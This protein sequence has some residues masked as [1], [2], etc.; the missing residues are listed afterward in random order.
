MAMI[1]LSKEATV[2]KALTP[3]AILMMLSFPVASQAAGLVIKNGTVYNANG[4]PVVDI[5]KSNGSGL[6]HNIWD[7]LNVDKNGVVFNN[8]ANE[9]STSLAGNI[10]GN[11][12]LTSGSAKVILNEVTSKNPSTING[13]MEVAG[14]KAD[15]IIANPNGITVNGGGSINTGKLTL[16]TG[17]PD[18]QDDKL[19]GYSVNGGTITLGKLDN[20][21][22][23][24]ILSRN[25]VVN[26]KVS[27]DELNVV[28]GNNY[29]NA[30]GQV[31]GSVSATGSRNGYSVDVAKLGGM[32]ANKINLVSTEKGVGVRNL[33][34]IAGGANG[35]SID[36]K[37]NLL[38]SN[39]QIQSASTINL[40]TN[41]TLDNTTG[42]VTSVG[43]ISL[44]TNKNTIVNTRAGNISTM[45]DIYVNSGTIDNT[46]GKLAA[47]GMLAVDTNSATL[48]NSG[49]GSSV[50]IEA[51]IVA[52]K[53]GTLNNSNGQIRGGYVGLESAALNNNNGDIQT[54][55]DIAIISNGN[56]DNNKGLIRSSTGHIV[57]GAAGSVN[58]G[59]TKT[60]DTG[61][62]DS[63]GIIADTGVEI[64]ANN[65]NNNGGQIASNGNVSL[66]SYST[67]DDYAGKVLSNS[68]VIIKGSSLRNDTG[69]ISAK[70]GIEV[71]V[72]GS[73]TNNIGVISSEE[74]DIS[75]LANSVDNHGGFMMGQNITMESM[76][77]VNN[78]TALIVASKKLKINAFGNIENRDGNSFGNTYGVYFGM[79]QQTGGMVG[80]EGIELSGQNI[81]N[82]N[83]RFIA[84]D[85]PLTLQ[86]QN[87]F[88]NTRALITSG[89]DAIIRAAG[90]FYNNY[91]TTYSA[92]NL[93]VY[94][95]SL[96]NASDGRLEDNT[97]TG[98]IAS[99]KNLDL[100]VDSS[101]TNYGWIS[102]K[103][104]VHF[105]VLK[106]TLY[107]RNA[108]AADN[109]LT[110]N[111]QNGV[112]NFKDIVAGTALTIDTQKYV[113]NNSNSNML[114]QTIAINAVNDINNRGNIVGDYSLGVKT[115]GNIYNYLNMLS[116]GV[117]GVSANKVTNSGKD[118]VLG[119][120]YGLALEANE[121]DNTGTIVGM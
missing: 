42:T 7:N 13:M 31:T 91:A 17:T 28:A 86:A 44:N 73:L 87:T 48:I 121:T 11:S 60:A 120:F 69:G 62:S 58:N 41:G 108:I 70:Q 27:A 14:D 84:E 114:G 95:A 34:V 23:T 107:N 24:E 46:N 72:G 19:A 68:K 75:L 33:G 8:S 47:A 12:N 37:G 80:N 1:N 83:S 30:A 82:N 6:S 49:K 67:I 112:E 32:Y 56:V 50:G 119:G 102:G 115:T 93:D 35:V 96:N 94:A 105:N 43:T 79:S 38:N 22:P 81:Y 118:A 57:I 97:A 77:G 92:G 117:A 9:S 26:G 45:G 74:G 2:G 29:V 10:Q 89:A 63:L 18:I 99:D 111:A 78:N 51:G 40:T 15:L 65:I 71:A 36:S 61:S 101:V 25:V 4:V 53:T 110:I 16:T 59:S 66:S 76:S 55:G 113:T 20:A 103:G 52:L 116:Y 39:A 64:G 109:A 98:V 106:G 104:D 5:N 90:T 54:T 3:I 88:D 21:S 85:G 100:S